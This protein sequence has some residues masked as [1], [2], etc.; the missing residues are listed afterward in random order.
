MGRMPASWGASEV[1]VVEALFER[2]GEL[3]REHVQRLGRRLVALLQRDAPELLEEPARS[4]PEVDPNPLR[5]LR[6]ALQLEVV[7]P[8]VDGSPAEE[9]ATGENPAGEDRA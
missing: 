8:G 9:G 1:A 4:R 7:Q 5:T 6:Q 2:A 3:E